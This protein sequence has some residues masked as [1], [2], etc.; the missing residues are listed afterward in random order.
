M[1]DTLFM[2]KPDDR[3]TCGEGH[4]LTVFQSKDMQD[5]PC[6]DHFHL[7]NDTVYVET[8]DTSS[9]I[10]LAK[11]QLYKVHKTS[12]EQAPISGT[13]RAY[14]HCSKCVPVCY[15]SD[16]LGGDTVQHRYPYAEYVLQLKNGHLKGVD[17]VERQARQDLR[18][19]LYS[20]CKANVLDDTDE[21]AKR[22]LEL[23]NDEGD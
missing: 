20:T 18:V 13:V 23:L 14:T 6:M 9:R 10:Q 17:L 12:L 22:H 4:T 15:V 16:H 19:F 21:L 2:G 5:Q 8:E 3:L 11:G 1:F 7:V